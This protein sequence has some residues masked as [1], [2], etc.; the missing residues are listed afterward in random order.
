MERK[1]AFWSSRWRWKGD[2]RMDFW[3]PFKT[4]SKTPT[5]T[6]VRILL[7][8]SAKIGSPS[9]LRRMTENAIHGFKF[10][11]LCGRMKEELLENNHVMKAITRG[12]HFYG[13]RKKKYV[14]IKYGYLWVKLLISRFRYPKNLKIILFIWGEI[15]TPVHAIQEYKVVWLIY[16][17]GLSKALRLNQ[18]WP[19]G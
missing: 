14:F 8:A 5:T 13:K 11:K 15:Y 19:L 10:R 1:I 17:Q 12:H 7:T 2:G 4:V 6:R 18:V 9:T 16:T 3:V